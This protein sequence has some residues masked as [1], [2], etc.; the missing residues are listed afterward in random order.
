MLQRNA[1][2]LHLLLMNSV[3]AIVL[4]QHLIFKKGNSEQQVKNISILLS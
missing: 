3:F 4:F 2:S 1:L